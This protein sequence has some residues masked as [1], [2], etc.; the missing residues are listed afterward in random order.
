[1][2]ERQWQDVLA[3]VKAQGQR[4]DLAYLRSQAPELGILALL[5]Q[6]LAELG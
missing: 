4:L 6:V 1:V 3:V 5:E 2:S